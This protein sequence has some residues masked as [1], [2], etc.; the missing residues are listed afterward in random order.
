MSKGEC[1]INSPIID[2]WPSV[3]PTD[4]CKYFDSKDSHDRYRRGITPACFD[5]RWYQEVNGGKDD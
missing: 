1:R 4:W 2:G 5:C 3:S